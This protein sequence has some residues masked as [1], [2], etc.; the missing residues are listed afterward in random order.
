[1]SV[2]T[3]TRYWDCS[4][5]ACGCAYLPF[6]PGSDDLPAH[7]Y[8][9]AMFAAPQGNP[10]G[11][12]FYGAAAVSQALGGGDWLAEG[13]GKCWKV[14]GTSNISPFDGVSTVLVLKATNYCPPLNP[15]CANGNP[16]FDIA[17]PGFDSQPASLSNSC[18]IREEDEIDGFTSCEQWMIA[19][20]NPNENCDCSLFNSD[21]LRDGCENFRT[22][23]WDNVQ[24]S[25]EEVTCPRELTRLPCWV[26]NGGR[27]PEGIPTFCASNVGS[28]PSPTNASPIPGPT[29]APTPMP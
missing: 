13:C 27:Y 4:G 7:C 21:V 18:L 1:M 16:H 29:P 19:S 8:S 28:G 24:V 11:A 2:A 17:A 20:G 23:Y 5:G 6:G 22:L 12:S 25:Y 10:Y 15:F 26:E 14:I 9:N 3:T